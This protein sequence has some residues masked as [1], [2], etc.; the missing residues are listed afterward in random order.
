MRALR[1]CCG[2]GLVVCLLSITGCDKSIPAYPVEGTV[3]F[4]DGTPIKFGTIELLSDEHKINARGTINREGK[5]RLTTYHPNDGAVAGKHRCV[6]AQH[7]VEMYGIK[8]NHDH[9][10]LVA[11]KYADYSTTD[12]VVV[13]EAKPNEI[14]LVVDKR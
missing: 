8:V 12:L 4:E 11:S 1:I 2:V 5:F 13:I 9:G 10:D 3:V 6:I 7:V 14:K